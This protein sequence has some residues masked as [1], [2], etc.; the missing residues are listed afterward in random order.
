[1]PD[2]D[3]KASHPTVAAAVLMVGV[4]VLIVALAWLGT[5]GR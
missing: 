5:S 3:R 2:D 1:M 4:V